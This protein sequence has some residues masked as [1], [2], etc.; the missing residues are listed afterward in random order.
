MSRI[1][2]LASHSNLGT[3]YKKLD[4]DCD[5]EGGTAIFERVFS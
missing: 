5:L 4:L 1:C 3:G 2:Q